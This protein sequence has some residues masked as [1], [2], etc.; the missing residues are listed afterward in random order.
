MVAPARV[1]ERFRMCADEESSFEN[2]NDGFKRKKV[3][4]NKKVACEWKK[5]YDV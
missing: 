2:E 5:S 3:C 1:M 4:W